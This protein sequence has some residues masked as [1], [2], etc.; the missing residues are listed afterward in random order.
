MQYHCEAYTTGG[1]VAILEQKHLS[2]WDGNEDYFQAINQERTG[3]VQVALGFKGFCVLCLFYQ[4]SDG[5]F[6]VYFDHLSFMV[7]SEISADEGYEIRYHFPPVEEAFTNKPPVRLD[8][9]G[10]KVC[11]FD[12]AIPGGAISLEEAGCQLTGYGIETEQGPYDA[13]LVDVGIGSWEAFDLYYKGNHLSF[14]GV[15]FR[16]IR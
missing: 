14:D 6:H 11:I 16:Q 9:F 3:C 13:A 2:L 15:L 10:G 7:L 5:N 4:E 1:P 12:A 8:D